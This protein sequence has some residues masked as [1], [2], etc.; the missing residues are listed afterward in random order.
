MWPARAPP[1]I[2]LQISS[3]C[4][5]R[6]TSKRPC[7]WSLWSHS[8]NGR[9]FRNT[10]GQETWDQ[11]GDQSV[12]PQSSRVSSSRTETGPHRCRTNALA[13]AR[14]GL[15]SE[16]CAVQIGIDERF[17][18]LGKTSFEI[19]LPLDRLAQENVWLGNDSLG[20]R[21]ARHRFESVAG[22]HQSL[23]SRRAVVR[24]EVR[25]PKRRSKAH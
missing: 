15:H 11:A 24:P 21:R 1:G 12:F 3:T 25:L 7:V 23:C 18:S 22:G 5:H 9:P 20:H 6:Q 13:L 16:F 4:N 19:W 17:S 8:I 14:T 10:T 2:V